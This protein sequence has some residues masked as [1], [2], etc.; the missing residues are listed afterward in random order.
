[1]R[2]CIPVIR[3]GEQYCELPSIEMVLNER[4]PGFRARLN[5][6]YFAVARYLAARMPWPGVRDF[7]LAD[8]SKFG[9]ARILLW[10]STVLRLIG[11]GFAVRRLSPPSCRSP[12]DFL[13]GDILFLPDASWDD[14][15]WR[16]VEDARSRGVRVVFLLYDLFPVTHPEY[17]VAR[18]IRK[19]ESW[20]PQMAMRADAVLCISD[21]TATALRGYLAQHRIGAPPEVDVAYLG[22]DI[23]RPKFNAMKNGKLAAALNSSEP[24][25]GCVGTLEP[26]KN[27]ELALD[28]FDRLWA[29]GHEFRLIIIGRVGW[30]CEDLLSRLA[31]HDALNRRLFWF[32]NVDDDDLVLAYERLAALVFA[33]HVEGFGLPLVEALALGV[34]AIANDIPVFREIAGDAALFFDTNNADSLASKVLDVSKIREAGR[35]RVARF[36][37]P[38]WSQSVETM[39]QKVVT[40][41]E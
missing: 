25:F 8:R 27:Y 33:S 3:E 15:S 38:S 41:V 20:L 30:L 14:M 35:S 5:Q 19:F 4:K 1:M 37:W 6:S 16:L 29:A 11:I 22:C 23:P 17:V 24:V 39:L 7:M 28:A 32:D 10:P 40:I 31:T 13:S 36:E 12:V 34:P 18:H 26:R 2:D 9:L 21:Y